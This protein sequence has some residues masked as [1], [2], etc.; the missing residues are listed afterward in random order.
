MD[1]EVL[2]KVLADRVMAENITIESLPD[3]VRDSVQEKVDEQK[4]I[5]NGN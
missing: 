3:F 4:N 1:N 2:I 5:N